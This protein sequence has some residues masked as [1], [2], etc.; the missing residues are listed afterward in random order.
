M[1]RLV[2]VQVSVLGGSALGAAHLFQ[3]LGKFF[4][5]AVGWLVFGNE[6]NTEGVL[7]VLA[8]GDEIVVTEN[9]E[10]EDLSAIYT[11]KVDCV[12]WQDMYILY[13]GAMDVKATNPLRVQILNA[14]RRGQRHQGWKL[15]RRAACLA[16]IRRH[17]IK[18]LARR[19][20]ACKI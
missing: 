16:Q 6:R 11:R 15:G 2:I 7:R 5:T 20:F 1:G 3:L 9:T 10:G 18:P 19:A 13:S 12:S 17:C 4:H 8:R 14:E